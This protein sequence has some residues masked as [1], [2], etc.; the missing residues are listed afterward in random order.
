MLVR[1]AA[2]IRIAVLGVL[3]LGCGGCICGRPSPPAPYRHAVVAAD[4]AIASRAGA[5]VMRAGGN[6]IDAAVATSFTLSVV[7]PY[8]CGIGGGGFMVIRL[9]D[10]GAE[11]QRELGRDVARELAINYREVA[12]A[13]ITPD[14][15]ERVEDKRASR[16]GGM[17]V[18]VPGSVAGLLH[19]HA[20]YGVLAR[21]RVMDPAIRAAETGF[22]VDEDYVEETRDLVKLFEEHPE[23]K[24]RFGFVWTR[25]LR[26]GA[27][28]VGDTISLPEQAAAL[29]LI[30][31]DGAAAFYGGP[32]GR[33]IVRAARERAGVLTD[34]DLA[35]FPVAEM[36]PLRF[37]FAGRTFLTMPPPS[38]GGVAMGQILGILEEAKS[39]TPNV[40]GLWDPASIHLV[41]EAM[42]HAFA[43]RAEWLGDPAF[44]DVPIERLLS[45]DY[46][47]ERADLIRL[48]RTRTPE[49]YGTR[50]GAVPAPPAPEDGGTSHFS[51]VDPLGSAVAC[52]ETIN[53]EF[54]SLVVVEEF[55]FCLNNQMDDFTTIGG[56]ANAFGLTQ[57]DLNRPQP[58]KRPLSS[59]TPTI[60]VDK[61]GQVEIVVGASG[62]PRIIS[63]TTL[64]VI[65]AMTGHGNAAYTVAVGRFHH[66]WQPDTLWFEDEPPAPTLFGGPA[67]GMSDSGRDELARYGHDLKPRREIGNV[68]LIRRHPLGPG[69][70]AACDARKGGEP[71]GW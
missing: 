24:E 45:R 69:W 30:A 13:A 5:E 42:K 32:I 43:D 21:E 70:D 18:G 28:K 33:A 55:G 61:D 31:R 64:A 2:V 50:R 4:H 1:T 34:A 26:E 25:L 3:V 53:L 67:I 35:S 36:E 38:S 46:L 22:A 66:Q 23:W 9:S 54:G 51:V 65:N 6:A 62:G 57:S 19:A 39:P 47:R 59:M 7:R 41:V 8:S 44:V 14:A 37:T 68:Q 58:G 12:P 15:F 40:F 11:Q 56:G 20:K 63:A 49:E 16:Y 48:T 27:V 29:R 10:A 60:V 52:T 71:A 17:A